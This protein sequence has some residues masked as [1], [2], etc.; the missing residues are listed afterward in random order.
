MSALC[1]RA[2]A[3]GAGS[4]PGRGRA[5]PQVPL[6]RASV[7]FSPSHAP[8]TFFAQQLSV[9][10]ESFGAIISSDVFS[11]PSSARGSR[12]PCNRHGNS[13][14]LCC[15]RLLESF[16]VLFWR[17][18]FCFGPSASSVLSSWCLILRW[19]HLPVGPCLEVPRGSVYPSRVCFS[20]EQTVQLA[21]TG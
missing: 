8:Q 19:A 1:A 5:R 11:G 14:R 9:K 18:C 21:V 3:P 12:C 6:S 7:A 20:S 13:H 2:P 17:A 10:S 4:R 15:S 16:C